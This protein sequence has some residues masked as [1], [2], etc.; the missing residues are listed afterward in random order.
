M[1]DS[2]RGL[3]IHR[4]RAKQ[5]ISFGGLI[6]RRSISPT[7][8][9]FLIDYNG[10]SFVYGEFKLIGAEEKKGQIRALENLVNSHEKA[11]HLS[12]AFIV[13][14]NVP[15]NDDIIPEILLI[16]RVYHNEKW[17]DWSLK[18]ATVLEFLRRWEIYCEK[19][20]NI[21]L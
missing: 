4:D 17:N 11:L 16:N 6:R 21:E 18:N 20:K 3:I 1:L 8:I 5:L 9:D 14:H 13:Y 12:C 2:D 7:D 10:K 19:I 15:I